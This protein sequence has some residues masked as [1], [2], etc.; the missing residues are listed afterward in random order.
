[1]PFTVQSVRQISGS[2]PPAVRIPSACSSRPN[3]SAA[4]RR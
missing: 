4:A 3:N 1:M 2:R